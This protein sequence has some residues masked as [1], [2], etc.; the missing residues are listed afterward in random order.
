MMDRNDFME[1]FRDTHKLNTLSSDDRIEVFRT[2]LT[3]SSDLSEE[4]L[5]DVCNEY[6]AL[7]PS[8]LPEE[9]TN[10]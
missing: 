7:L 9:I 1:F 3:G 6:G 2:V 8:E 4:L 10:E 5:H